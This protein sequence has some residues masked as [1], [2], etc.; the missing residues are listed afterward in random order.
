VACAARPTAP[1]DRSVAGW[2]SANCS[3]ERSPDAAELLLTLAGSPRKQGAYLSGLIRA[4]AAVRLMNTA[5]KEEYESL[6]QEMQDL[7]AR[8]DRL[9]TLVEGTLLPPT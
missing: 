9:Q 2:R 6:Q 8:V 1:Q 7:R 4:A 5:P 3:T